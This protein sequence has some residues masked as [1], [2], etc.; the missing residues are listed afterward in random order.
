MR[1]I[2]TR[3]YSCL[4]L[5]TA[6]RK[7]AITNIKSSNNLDVTNQRLVKTDTVFNQ[8]WKESSGP[9]FALEAS[10][11]TVSNCWFSNEEI[12]SWGFCFS[13]MFSLRVLQGLVEN[14][15]FFF[16]SSRF[17]GKLIYSVTIR[18][19]FVYFNWSVSCKTN[20]LGLELIE[21]FD[22]LS[23]LSFWKYLKNIWK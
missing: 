18:D 19:F 13:I 15:S 1:N 22:E 9:S 6:V 20:I 12:H 5:N 16:L 11:I 23:K 2:V 14:S 10:K 17:C 21:E 4:Q 8:E 7:S 3:I